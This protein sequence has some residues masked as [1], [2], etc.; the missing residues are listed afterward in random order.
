MGKSFGE[1]TKLAKILVKHVPS[2]I[3]Y[4]VKVGKDKY[5]PVSREWFNLK[6]STKR[7][8][9]AERNGQVLDSDASVFGVL[10]DGSKRQGKEIYPSS[11]FGVSSDT[12]FVGTPDYI[13]W[14]REVCSD[15]T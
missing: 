15:C 6:N 11:K 2:E 13:R 3:W 4:V 12:S 14:V 5:F 8:Y 10:Q 1:A 7:V 9:H